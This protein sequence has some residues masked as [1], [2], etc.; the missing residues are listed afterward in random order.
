MSGNIIS[1][2]LIL[3]GNVFPRREVRLSVKLSGD[4][5]KA[6]AYSLSIGLI[7]SLP[8]ITSKLSK[9]D[10]MSSSLDFL[11]FAFCLLMEVIRKSYKGRIGLSL[12]F[13][14]QNL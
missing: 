6:L 13:V 5:S 10:I 7:L 14:I 12:Y 1:M 9:S 3:L 2:V 11:A 4:S 8:T